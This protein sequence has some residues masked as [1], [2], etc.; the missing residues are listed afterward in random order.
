MIVE[1]HLVKSEFALTERRSP[2][3]FPSAL[4]FSMQHHPALLLCGRIRLQTSCGR[5]IRWVKEK[6]KESRAVN[7]DQSETEVCFLARLRARCQGSLV[8]KKNSQPP[9]AS[10]QAPTHLPCT[11]EPPASVRCVC[12]CMCCVVSEVRAAWHRCDF[13]F[14]RF[15]NVCSR[16]FT[17]SL[18]ALITH[19]E[20]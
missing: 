10:L 13:T 17:T 4:G 19:F 15:N 1:S 5:S 8:K 20:L 12:T 7:K 3:H 11:G 16:N 6:G 14:G 18:P 2:A 9:R